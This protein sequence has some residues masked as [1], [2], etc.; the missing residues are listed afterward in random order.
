MDFD[1][2]EGQ[3]DH[4]ISKYIKTENEEENHEDEM[5]CKCSSHISCDQENFGKGIIDWVGCDKCKRWFHCDCFFSTTMSI[6]ETYF[7]CAEC[8]KR[9]NQKNLVLNMKNLRETTITEERRDDKQLLQEDSRVETRG[10]KKKK[11]EKKRVGPKRPLAPFMVYTIKK[12][13]DLM[14]EN[15]KTKIS[16]ISKML[17]KE[18]RSLSENDKFPYVERSREEQE[19]YRKELEEF[20]KNQ[21]VEYEP[22]LFL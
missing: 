14:K 18:W 6:P 8:L 4:L 22:S 17:G 12:R 2:S 19:R 5:V 9:E 11:K 1:S 10:R 20:R 3:I 15:P 16:E 13:K 21:K 7:I